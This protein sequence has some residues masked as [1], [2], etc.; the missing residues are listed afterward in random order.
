VGI[1]KVTQRWTCDQLGWPRSTMRYQERPRPR[2]ARLKPLLARLALAKPRWGYRRIHLDVLKFEQVCQDTIQRLWRTM[3][4]QVPLRPH[5]PKR[6]RNLTP[7]KGLR[8]RRPHHVWCLDFLK[9]RTRDGR[10]LRFL[11]VVDEYTRRCL[12]L[13]VDVRFRAVDVLAVLDRLLAIHGRPLFIRSDNGPEFVAKEVARWA[14]LRGIILVRSAPASPW[15]NP[16]A[17]TFHSR[18]RDELV[19]QEDFGSLAEARQLAEAY[20]V[21]Y[22]DERPH[23][24]LGYQTP[25]AFAVK[26]VATT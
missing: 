3:Q 21:W 25:A 1:P 20:R 23:S 4:L 14:K 9:D 5:R 12:A 24:A 15:Q 6:V 10:G 16:F 19:E 11:S 18:L 13:D 22:N 7:V 17:E 26:A 8:A 2:D